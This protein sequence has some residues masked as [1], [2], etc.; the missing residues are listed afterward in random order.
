MFTPAGQRTKSKLLHSPSSVTSLGKGG[1]LI[2]S[3]EGTGY[4]EGSACS[5]DDPCLVVH[6]TED[7]VMDA[8]LEAAGNQIH[9]F[10]EPPAFLDTTSPE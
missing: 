2:L 6:W 9:N 3:P 8:L 7:G 5:V 10:P 1:E 4:I